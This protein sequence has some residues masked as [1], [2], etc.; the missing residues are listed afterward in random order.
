M[1]GALPVEVVRACRD[2]VLGRLCRPV[3]DACSVGVLEPLRRGAPL[4]LSE[5]SGG[6]LTDGLLS[7]LN[8]GLVVTD[9]GG[10]I[11]PS[12]A[13]DWELNGGLVVTGRGGGRIEPS[14]DPGRVLAG[15]ALCDILPVRVSRDVEV[16]ELGGLMGS[17]LGDWLPVLAESTRS[18]PRLLPP[19]ASGACSLFN[20]FNLDFKS[21]P[22]LGF[23]MERVRL[24]SGAVAIVLLHLQ[25]FVYFVAVVREPR[26]W[27]GLVSR[28]TTNSE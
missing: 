14:L 19:G 23:R 10:R 11:E 8:G 5:D 9:R 20:P 26:K 17:L 1:E 22:A 28:V 4:W 3:E 15:A 25:A 6:L 16:L 24:G 21:I 2:V 18:P 12:L 7:E 13:P 27:R